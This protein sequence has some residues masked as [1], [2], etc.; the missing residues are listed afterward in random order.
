MLTLDGN[1]MTLMG[2]AD[3]Q[4]R[5]VALFR[6][7]L[8]EGMLRRAWR[9]LLGRP[10]YLRV[11]SEAGRAGQHDL[12]RRTVA[13]AEI[14]GSEGRAADFD[15]AFAPLDERAR[16]RWASVARARSGGRSLPPV[17]LIR[18]ADGYYVRDGHHRISVARAFG[19]EFIEAEVVSWA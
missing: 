1:A 14:V 4:Q 2:R 19:E 10:S 17:R 5:A 18:T 15:D 13:I 8:N 3:A 7:Q 16:D 6:R 12:G 9:R 11:L